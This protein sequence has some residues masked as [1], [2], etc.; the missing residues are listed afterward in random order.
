MLQ[1]LHESDDSIVL[2]IIGKFVVVYSDDILI[3]RRTQKQH[4]DHPRQVL[5]TLQTEKFYASLKKCA[6]C[7]DMIVFLEFVVSFEGVSVDHEKVKVITEWPQP[8]KSE[9]SGVFMG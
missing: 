1:H 4:V 8:Q 6:L 7:T 5:R 9:K 2:V 3:Y